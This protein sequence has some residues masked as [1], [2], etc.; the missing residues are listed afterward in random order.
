MAIKSRWTNQF[1]TLEHNSN[2]HNNV[3]NIFATDSF[4]NGLSCYQEVPVIDL[5]PDY[6]SAAH[7][8]DWYIEEL[9]LI[10]ELHGRQ[11][12]EVVTFGKTSYEEAQADFKSGQLRDRLKKQ[13]AEEA[14]YDYVEISYKDCVKLD[15]HKLKNLIF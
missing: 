15:A 11:H 8:F 1:K 9:N 4:F 13:A 6:H 12:Y 2:L 14:G 3:R 10:I 5:C 7:R